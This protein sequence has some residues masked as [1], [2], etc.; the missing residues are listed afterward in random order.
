VG[1]VTEVVS[2]TEKESSDLDDGG[3]LPGL[4]QKYL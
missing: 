2:F 3:A 1:L 4:C